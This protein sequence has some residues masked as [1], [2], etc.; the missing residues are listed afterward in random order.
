MGR[1]PSLIHDL[2]SAAAQKGAA[3]E[4]VRFKTQS[5]SY[6][7]LD[8]LS[9]R[10][11]RLLQT[12]GV[13]KGDRV[14]LYLDK[15][16]SCLPALYGALKAG[17]AYVPVD[18]LAPVRRA[19]YIVENCETKALVTTREKWEK[20]QPLLKCPPL[21]LVVLTDLDAEQ[22][23][24]GRLCRLRP[25]SEVLHTPAEA[26]PVA[27]GD[28]DL[29][30]ILYTSGSTGSPKGVMLTHRAG[31]TFI[32]WAA[33]QFRIEA[34]DRLSNHAPLHFDLS[35]F[36]LFAAAAA[37]ACVS[38]VPPELSIFAAEL[39]DFI[40]REKITVW[41]S[42]PSV[43]TR[44]VLYGRL[45][46]HRF[47]NLR[48]VLFAGEVFPTKYL[49]QL[50]R[51]IPQARFFNL[52]G[53]TETNVCTYYA[54][55]NFC[56]DR[57]DALPIGKACARC[58]LRVVDERLCATTPGEV[59]ELL[60]RGPSLMGGYWGM[61]ERTGEALV[62]LPGDEEVGPFY[63][64]GDLVRED[65]RGDL[66]FLGRRDD[67][68]KSRG[69]RIELG[70]IEAALHSHPCVEAA[71]A[72][73]VPDEEIGNVIKAVIVKGLEGDVNERVLKQYCLERLPRYMVPDLIEFRSSLPRTSSGKVDKNRLV[74]EHLRRPST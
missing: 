9:S 40:D 17:A 3:R 4:A 61:P 5:V 42:V 72:I 64:T 37:G 27:V 36:D 34:D 66:L 73:P 16:T 71:A 63:R 49:Q 48:T 8:E 21:R 7:E 1:R 6:G 60:V 26:R 51:A 30:Y 32:R 29:A 54:V 43:L 65:P 67:M 68:I 56:L 52:Y 45:E 38:L 24:P 2:L 41:Y 57:T 13:A 28:Q 14:G 44:L 74:Q 19:A 33:K 39:A 22:G 23:A 11:A 55:E 18:P 53:P 58:Q 59:G 47:Q 70:E 46:R 50:R 35:V 69:Y 31:L 62:R 10:L 25:W 20:L 12:E 15:S